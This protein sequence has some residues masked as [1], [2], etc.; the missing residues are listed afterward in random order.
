[1]ATAPDP[2]PTLLTTEEAAAYLRCSVVTI[3]RAIARGEL[4]AVRL[5]DVLRIARTE[6]DNLGRRPVKS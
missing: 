1:M 4:P 3:R 2:L 5:G 6:L